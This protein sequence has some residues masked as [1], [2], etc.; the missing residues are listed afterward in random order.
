MNTPSHFTLN[1]AGNGISWKRGIAILVVLTLMAGCGS[2]ALPSGSGGNTAFSSQN[3]VG[4]P[5][6]PTSAGGPSSKSAAPVVSGT[7]A[8]R[9]IAHS[10]AASYIVPKG[11]FLATFNYFVARATALGGYVVSSSSSGTNDAP[12][13]QGS[14]VLG[15]PGNNLTALLSSLPADISVRSLIYSTTDETNAEIALQASISTLTTEAGALDKVMATTTTVA[16]IISLEQEL[17]TVN[18]QLVDDQNQLNALQQEVAYS[19]ATIQIT[20]QHAKV[21]AHSP[22]SAFLHAIA[23][24]WSNA[25]GIVSFLVAAI[26]TLA[27]ILALLAVIAS[28]FAARSRKGT[29]AEI[30]GDDSEG[31]TPAGGAPE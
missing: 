30:G 28:I 9:Q 7:P 15:V 3:G 8:G 26:I 4:A 18:A 13:T 5:V 14:V 19:L 21:I 27:P 25:V 11:K 29:R 23:V 24:G 1:H 17:Q 10:V 16:N 20:E 22:P 6:F 12:I 31:T 2:A